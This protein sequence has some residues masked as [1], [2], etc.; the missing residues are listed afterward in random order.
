MR[1]LLFLTTDYHYLLLWDA[2]CLARN[3]AKALA[4]ARQYGRKGK[5]LVLNSAASEKSV[6]WSEGSDCCF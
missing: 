5:L 4:W 3:E 6:T 1:P 2:H